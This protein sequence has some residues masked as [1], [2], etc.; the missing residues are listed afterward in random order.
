MARFQD[1][2]NYFNLVEELGEGGSSLEE[3]MLILGKE[4]VGDKVG[5]DCFPYDFFKNLDKVRG[6]GDGPVGFG[7]ATFTP[8]LRTGHN[9]ASL[10]RDA[11]SW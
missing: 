5:N 6:K 8:R 2:C 3:T 7:V 9:I 10:Y 4:V 1:S 11:M